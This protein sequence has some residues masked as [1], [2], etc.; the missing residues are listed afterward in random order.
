MAKV[1][2]GARLPVAARQLLG[3]F[4]VIEPESAPFSDE[5]LVAR[6]GDCDALIALLTQQIGAPLFERA[7]RLRLVANVA[8]GVDNI[9]L[10]AAAARGIAISHTPDVLTEATADFTFAQLLAAARRIPEGEALVRSGQ[11]PGW[12]LDQLLGAEVQGATLGIVG[13]GRIGRAVAAR[14]RGFAMKIVY[15]SPRPMLAH[16]AWA[17]DA[18]H[19]P[20]LELLA[21]ADFVSLHCPASPATQHLI[22]AAE[23]AAMKP[24][25][26][27]INTAR[28]TVVDE[29]ALAQALRAGC[30]AGA[31]LDVFE[32]EP[33]ISPELFTA[34]HL[35]LTPHLGSATVAARTRMAMI[36]AESVVDLFAG[37]SVR[38]RVS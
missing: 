9:D 8:V 6:V 37:G 17:L 30:I 24:S 21:R 36:A 4:D 32:R 27:L 14:A 22:G 25:A 1:L 26:L 29:T 28:G 31:A 35:L 12:A 16:I 19:L 11:W 18:T 10:A 7:S 23:L 38:H 34:P 2:L 13:M 33:A 15:A 20:L 5:E 3:A